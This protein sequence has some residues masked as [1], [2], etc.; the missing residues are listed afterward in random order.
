MKIKTNTLIFKKYK[1]KKLIYQSKLS[2]VYEGINIINNEPVAIKF[3]KKNREDF[4]VSESFFFF[5]F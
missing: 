5:F 2:A 1:V 3:E 4:L